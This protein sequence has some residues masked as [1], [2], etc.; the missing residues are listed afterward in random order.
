MQTDLKINSPLLSLLALGI[1]TLGYLLA[2]SSVL[3]SSSYDATRFHEVS[4][5]EILPIITGVVGDSKVLIPTDLVFTQE[6]SQSASASL[7]EAGVTIMQIDVSV[8]SS[9]IEWLDA[10]NKFSKFQYIP[11]SNGTQKKIIGVEEAF[12]KTIPE[13][14]KKVKKGFLQG[15]KK[16]PI[17]VLPYGDLYKDGY[18]EVTEFHIYDPESDSVIQFRFVAYTVKDK[19]SLI[20]RDTFTKSL[21]DKPKKSKKT[22]STKSVAGNLY[23]SDL[24]T[25][26]IPKGWSTAGS[27][28][29]VQIVSPDELAVLIVNLEPGSLLDYTHA[30]YAVTVDILKKTYKTE[31]DNFAFVGSKKT[32]LAGMPALI[33]EY[34]MTFADIPLRGYQ[35]LTSKQG[36]DYI[37]SATIHKPLWNT[38]K[39]PVKQMIDTFKLEMVTIQGTVSI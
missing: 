34:K 14:S 30:E 23:D 5:H 18:S 38:Y 25:M 2:P 7:G 39:S 26:M 3:A 10:K 9:D 6:D 20:M 16:S 31:L 13:N 12:K 17:L 21:L 15:L 35:V 11:S 33:F 28:S 19:Q 29:K 1:F 37:L 27:G 8:R 36:I 24:F 22:K 32:N 4:I